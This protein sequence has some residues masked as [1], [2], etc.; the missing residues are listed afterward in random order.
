[1]LQD[2]YQFCRCIGANTAL[3][4]SLVL[5]DRLTPMISSS[6]LPAVALG[7]SVESATLD[8]AQ[9]ASVGPKGQTLM[10]LTS[11]VSQCSYQPNYTYRQQP[12]CDIDNLLLYYAATAKQARFP[13][14]GCIGILRMLCFSAWCFSM[15]DRTSIRQSVR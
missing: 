2:L 9:R 12:I 5:N 3:P 6:S 11:T 1:M 10:G 7:S 4:I 13:G 15:T 14:S 8:G